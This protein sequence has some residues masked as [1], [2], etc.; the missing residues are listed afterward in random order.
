VDCTAVVRDDVRE[1]PRADWDRLQHPSFYLS[2]DWLAARS[3]TIGGRAHFVLA[4]GGDGDPLLA[5]PF[6]TVTEASHRGYDP[7]ELLL[8]PVDAPARGNA[9]D[10]AAVADLRAT[11]AREHERL[12]PAVVVAAPGRSGGVSYAR[13]L[14]GGRRREV[15]EAAATVVEETAERG[16]APVTAWLYL[17]EG[18]AALHDVLTTRGYAA[19][20]MDAESYLPI[21]WPTFE[22]YLRNLSANRRKSA[23]REMA[24]LA[25]AGVDLEL[26]GPSALDRELA[27]LEIQWRAK[28]G[29]RLSL[30]EVEAQHELLRTVLGPSVLVFVA[31][32]QGRAVG[33]TVFFEHGDTWYS[34]FGGF[35]YTAGPLFAYFNLVFYA[36][37]KEAIRRGVTAIRYSTGAHETKRSRGCLL[38][39]LLMYVRLPSTLATT[40]RPGLTALDRLQRRR[41]ANLAAG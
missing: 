41:F 25:E 31:R 24:R 4:R 23:R 30:A 35:D 12:R 38:A 32:R 17:P 10:H 27:G 40:A 13:D 8:R 3:I 18:D 34:R 37:L 6:Y 19:V 11:L 15:L 28:Y 2:Y 33:F 14:E 7:I 16:A 9:A 29:R 20:V 36:P 26:R 5:V 22:A 39:N 1:L 21:R